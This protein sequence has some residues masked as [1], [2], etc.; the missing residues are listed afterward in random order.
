LIHSPD[1]LDP[2]FPYR[3]TPL[4]LINGEEQLMHERRFQADVNILRSPQR[5]S[6]LEVSR[7]VQSC[8]YAFAPRSVLD[9]G[10]GSG[11][12][13]EAFAAQ[14]LVVAGID[15]NPEMIDVAQSFVPQG[16][17]KI[18]TAENIPDKDKAFDLVF[19]GLVL[20]E[21]DS[22]LQA[23]QEAHRVARTGAAV[24]E[25]P[26]REEEFGPPLAHRL[27]PTQ[28]TNLANYAG[29]REVELLAMTDLVLFLLHF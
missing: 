18:A 11:I 23:L 7:V 15:V 12:F 13:A 17:F 20:H 4:F 28:V 21:T 5:M 6:R 16:V 14:G 24:L 27:P 10:T 19:L 1:L 29:F 25:W 3:S 9:V 8:Q 26:Y 22:P 2:D